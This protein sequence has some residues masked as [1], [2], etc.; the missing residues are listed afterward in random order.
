M[1]R[2]ARLLVATAG[3]LA[4]AAP[5][6]A[7]QPNIVV[8]MS[9]DQPYGSIGEMPYLSSLPG[10]EPFGTLYVNNALCCPSRATFLSGQYSHHTGVQLNREGGR[11]DP[12]ETIATWLRRDGYQTGLFGKYLNTYPF[13]RGP[14]YIP[15]GWDRWVA[16]ADKGDPRYYN[17][18]LSLDGVEIR[19]GGFEQDYSTDV[20]ARL[21][22]DFID[23]APQ[24]FFALI[25]PTAPHLP[26]IPTPRHAGLYAEEP[27]EIP[28]NFDR[29]AHGAPAYY[30]DAPGTTVAEQQNVWRLQMETLRAVD[31][32]AERVV[33]AADARGPTIFVYLSDNGYSLGSHRIPFKRCG[34]EECGRVPGLIRSPGDPTGVFA[35]NADLAPTLAELA[36]VRSGPT[37]GRSLV[38]AMQ[39]AS[40]KHPAVLLHS[41]S[42]NE[43]SDFG[44]D[45]PGYWGLRTPRWKYLKHAPAA[46]APGEELYDLSEDPFEL[47]NLATR[48]RFRSVAD[49]LDRRM[50]RLR[51]VRPS[52]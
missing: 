44:L 13:H 12:R 10:L 35:S 9:D 23:D 31:E 28:P 36:G 43:G 1:G 8:V 42:K 49:G 52:R 19:F 5:A 30:R 18:A 51:A 17:Y 41:K 46:G 2:V 27:F 32:L 21:A 7:A 47:E 39:G 4:L 16:M 48:G 20:L 38:P 45:L 24:P 6:H 33:T 26:Y 37:D 25:T 14:A 40:Q 34:Y 22:E 15:P 3:T 50:V 29:A 11:F